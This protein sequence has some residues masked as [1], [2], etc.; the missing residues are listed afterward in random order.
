MRSL[1]FL[2]FGSP[3]VANFADETRSLIDAVRSYQAKQ[4]ITSQQ[5]G[6]AEAQLDKAGKWVP[7]GSHIFKVKFDTVKSD[8]APKAVKR[9]K[10][11]PASSVKDLKFKR[12]S[13]GK[14]SESAE[15]KRKY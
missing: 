2:A 9:E 12:T 7:G 14:S 3:N 4:L 6:S 10:V 13:S 1:R 11:S 15:K 5:R 8:M